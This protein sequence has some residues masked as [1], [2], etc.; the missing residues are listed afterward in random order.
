V[1]VRAVTAV[2]VLKDFRRTCG[3]DRAPAFESSRIRRAH[4]AGKG[5]P[6]GARGSRTRVSRTMRCKIGEWVFLADQSCQFGKRILGTAN[7]PPGRLRGP[8]G[9]WRPK[10]AVVGH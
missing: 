1:L 4:I 10:S 6:L 3:R 7:A 9:S 2:E 5:T 8:L